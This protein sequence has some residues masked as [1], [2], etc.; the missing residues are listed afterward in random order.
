MEEKNILY[1]FGLNLKI[2]RQKRKMSQ[3]ELSELTGFSIP[4]ISNVE[5]GKHNISLNSALKFAKV[6]DK[7]IEDMIKEL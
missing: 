5:L 3:E 6:F 4:Y 7:N 2:C 1:N